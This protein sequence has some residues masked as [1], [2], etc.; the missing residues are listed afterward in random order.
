MAREAL[1]TR[2]SD[3]ADSFLWS[4]PRL[5]GRL[6]VVGNIELGLRRTGCAR[7][8]PR[9]VMEGWSYGVLRRRRSAFE[10]QVGNP[11]RDA[12][13]SDTFRYPDHHF[14]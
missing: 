1:R 11:D 10:W 12:P 2:S 14:Q 6:R 4:A 9:G 7:I 5:R 3:F 8:R 13:R